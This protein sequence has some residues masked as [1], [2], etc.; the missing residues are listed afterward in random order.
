MRLTR[1]G[2]ELPCLLSLSALTVGL[3]ICLSICLVL[4]QTFHL[5][6]ALNTHDSLFSKG[7][8]MMRCLSPF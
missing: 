6:T 2:E 5:S 3:S 7:I 4:E 8:G 1:S